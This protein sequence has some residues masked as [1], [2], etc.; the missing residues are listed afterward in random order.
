MA[1]SIRNNVIK[2]L[3]LFGSGMAFLSPCR[4]SSRIFFFFPFYHIGGA[5]KV[6]LDILTL[7][8]D[9]KPWIIIDLKSNSPAF[10]KEF[11]KSGRLIDLSALL[12]YSLSRIILTGYFSSL[13]NRFEKVLLF[14]ANSHFYYELLPHLH[15]HVYCIDL[16]H[17][18][19]G[20]IE[21]YSL[22]YV[23]RIDRRIVINKKTYDDLKEQYAL[24][25]IRLGLI[26]RVDVIGNKVNL[27]KER[28]VKKDR[29]KLRIIYVGRGTEEKR[30]HLVGRIACLC[31][32]KGLPVEFT[33]V[34]NVM[35][36]VDPNDKNF[37]K[38]IEEIHDPAQIERLYRQSDLLLITSSREG[39]PMVIMEAMAHG[40][41]PVTTDVGGIPYH[42]Q[43]GKN[44]FLVANY[45]IEEQIVGSF[46]DIIQDLLGNRALLNQ[47]SKKAYKY[48]TQHFG[49]D[50]FDTY[51]RN[52]F[53]KFT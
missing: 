50:L 29:K 14:G 27:P 25:G 21:C 3:Y 31:H 39:F 46:L 4:N 13:I 18:F 9:K 47:V 45:D 48:A 34:G 15:N 52:L 2:I 51:Y 17:A 1:Q 10:K 42:I 20:G 5:E 30:V 11:A 33:L 53:S 19:G 7:A 26:G 16:I 44:G 35:D 32:E 38:L 22:P 36:A 40:V 6:H 12:G 23:S 28:P 37:I 49:S 41:V 24:N 8:S 43:H